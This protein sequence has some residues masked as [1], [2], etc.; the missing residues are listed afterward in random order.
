MLGRRTRLIGYVHG[1]E[2]LWAHKIFFHDQKLVDFSF[3]LKIL[4]ELGKGFSNLC[5]IFKKS[6][7][8]ALWVSI[9]LVKWA[10]FQ[11]L[12]LDIL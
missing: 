6:S 7:D 3:Q 4:L 9:P 10:P 12:M 8:W 11:K 5:R 2:A 1:V